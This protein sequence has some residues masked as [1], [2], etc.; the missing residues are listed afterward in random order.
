MLTSEREKIVLEDDGASPVHRA[1][2][3]RFAFR[4]KTRGDM[5]RLPGVLVVRK[6]TSTAL[7]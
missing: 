5:I 3:A 1:R 7:S 6:V 2:V 4:W